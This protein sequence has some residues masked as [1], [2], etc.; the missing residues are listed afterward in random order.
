MPET[1][2]FDQI[3]TTAR[4]SGDYLR[5]CQLEITAGMRE[6]YSDSP[7]REVEPTG[8]Y[9]GTF[10]AEIVNC[11]LEPR[12]LIAGPS[13]FEWPDQRMFIA[14]RVTRVTMTDNM[15]GYTL[16]AVHGDVLGIARY[17]AERLSEAD[18]RRQ[19]GMPPKSPS[20][21]RPPTSITSRGT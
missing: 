20:C 19:L 16:T 7:W 9:T 14:M 3:A 12:Q 17:G 21:L 11:S 1:P 4:P 5:S 2:D 6:K 13:V 18:A 10:D 15:A 8:T